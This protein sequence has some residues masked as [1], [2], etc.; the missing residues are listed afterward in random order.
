MKVY[1]PFKKIYED[2]KDTFEYKL[3]DLSIQ[4]TENVL[5]MMEKRGINRNELAK[6]M[7]VSR[8]SITQFLNEGSNITIKRLLKLSEALDC[9]IEIQIVDKG[10]ILDREYNFQKDFSMSSDSYKLSFADDYKEGNINAE[11]ACG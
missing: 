4:I 10:E 1:G 9:K 7:G 8:A 5:E 6:K 2:V 3:A 11:A